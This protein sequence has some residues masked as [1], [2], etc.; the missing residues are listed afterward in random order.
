MSLKVNLRHLEDK[1][2][3][4]KGEVPVEELDFGQEDELMR[5]TQPL[6]HDLEVELMQEGLLVRGRLHL[7]VECEC[8][9]CLKPFRV[10]IDLPEWCCHV[11]LEGEESATV[12]NDCVDLTPYVREDILL[13]LPQ[14]PLC[15]PE[16]DSL[17][18]RPKP[19]GGASQAVKNT[20]AWAALD[21]LKLERD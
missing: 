1:T 19:K 20:A 4:L 17:P 18:G 16:C 15:K 13:A 10:A 9:R 14:R 21:Q 11:A 7:P 6:T 3:T 8:S 2:I 5:F 12:D